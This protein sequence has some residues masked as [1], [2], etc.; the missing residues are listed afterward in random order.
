MRFQIL[1]TH[2]SSVHGQSSL[3]KSQGS[4]TL[5]TFL[6]LKSYLPDIS[7][8]HLYPHSPYPKPFLNAITPGSN[9]H[10]ISLYTLSSSFSTVMTNLSTIHQPINQY[11]HPQKTLTYKYDNSTNKCECYKTLIFKCNKVMIT[12]MV[13]IWVSTKTIAII[14]ILS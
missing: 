6:L 5:L 9:N 11:I 2:R 10:Q 4:G 14:K 8:P 3:L 7:H 13:S 12:I 1:P